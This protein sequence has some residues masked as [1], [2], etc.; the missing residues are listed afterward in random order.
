MAG[1]LDKKTRFMDTFLTDRGRQELAKG[2]LRFSFATFSDY[3]TFYDSSLDDPKVASD[4]TVRIQFEACNRAQDLVIPEFDSDGGMFFPAGGFDIINGQLS[5]LSGS[6]TGLVKGQLLVASASEAVSDSMNSFLDM[7][8]LRSEEPVE[9]STGFSIS[10]TSKS[11]LINDSKPIPKNKPN[12][13]ML[14]NVESLWQD[15]KLSHVPNY[16]L[17]PPVNKVS[18]RKLKK[19]P[20]LQQPAPLSY[21]DLRKE[22]DGD[23]SGWTGVGD[24]AEVV[25]EKTSNANNLVCQ[26][27]EVT[28]GSINKLRMIDFGEFEDSDPFSPGKHVFFVGKLMDDDAGDKTFINLFTVV[29]D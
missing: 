5:V 7:R 17:L 8:P 22:L 25:F 15:R 14:N 23:A 4:A 26:V 21:D 19:Y 16:Q 28:S 24:P 18:K 27:W 13:A 12:V 1:I 6:S 10:Q 29:F 11:F 3:G 20:A 2:E 9:K